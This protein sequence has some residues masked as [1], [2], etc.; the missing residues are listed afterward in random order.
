MNRKQIIFMWLGI[1]VFVLIGLDTIRYGGICLWSSG[2]RGGGTL[3]LP[4]FIVLWI[5][6]IVVTAGLIYTFRNKKD[7]TN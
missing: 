6:V 7:K 5:C 1:A 2:G 3:E 4:S